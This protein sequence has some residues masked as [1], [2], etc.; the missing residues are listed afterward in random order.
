MEGVSGPGGPA[1]VAAETR[2]GVGWGSGG[3]DTEE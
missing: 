1:G 2:R 3:G